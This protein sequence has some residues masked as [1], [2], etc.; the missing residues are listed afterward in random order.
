MRKIFI[1]VEMA[2]DIKKFHEETG[3]SALGDDGKEYPSGERQ[4]I[5]SDIR[6]ENLHDQVRRMMRSELDRFAE[7]Q[8]FDTFDEANDFDI[9]D[10]VDEFGPGF[11]VAEMEEEFLP[12]Q[13]S[14]VLQ[15]ELNN[16]KAEPE[17]VD[18]PTE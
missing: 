14:K 17:S 1:P 8:G 11:A 12:D 6:P 2:E 7:A 13:E 9:S 18:N 10:D 15:E 16:P 4:F 3:L 5:H